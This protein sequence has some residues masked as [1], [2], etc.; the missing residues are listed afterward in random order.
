MTKS[1]GGLIS[2]VILL[3][4]FIIGGVFAVQILGSTDQGV[5]LTDTQYGDQ[6]NSTTDM[7]IVSL[8]I[9]SFIPWILVVLGLFVAVFMLK[10]FVS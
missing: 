10:V 1:M 9:M 2:I 8:K 6:Y 7:T 3:S 5:N 4:I